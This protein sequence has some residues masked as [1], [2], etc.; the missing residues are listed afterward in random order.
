VRLRDRSRH[1]P[2][3]CCWFSI[4]LITFY[5]AVL[6]SAWF[7]GLW[8]GV[9]A[10]I[11]STLLVD[12]VWLAPLRAAGS[13]TIGDPVALMLSVAIGLAIRGFSE[14]RHRSTTREHEG[15]QR[16]EEREDALRQSEHR[17]RVAL[18]AEQ[19][20]RADAEDANHLKDHFM[21]VVSHGLRPHLA[22]QRSCRFPSTRSAAPASVIC[23]AI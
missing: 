17:R 9:V 1:R 5:P 14:S 2:A 8:P 4:P 23:A 13:T 20:S 10:T 3:G 16:T 11:L 6:L 15:R 7:G 12:Y 21:A 19:T 18:A 22:W